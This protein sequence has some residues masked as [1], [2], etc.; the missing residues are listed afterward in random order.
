MN[1]DRN[2]QRSLL[3][4][5]V[6]SVGVGPARQSQNKP[7]V[8]AVPRLVQ[9][10]GSFQ[11]P[12][13]QSGGL[14]GATFGIYREQDGGAAL[15]NEAE[16]RGGSRWELHGAVRLA[17]ERG[18]AGGAFCGGRIPVAAGYLSSAGRGDRAAGLVGKRS[19]CAESGGCGN[20]RR[21][22]A[23]CIRSSRGRF[24]LNDRFGEQ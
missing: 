4:A 23:L 6:F 5:L 1:K 24:Q 18:T 16:P 12:A 14:V 10:S 17:Q 13:G 7:Q 15:W 21:T 2:I 19:V 3:L 9:F 11:S 20:D 8:T 22:A